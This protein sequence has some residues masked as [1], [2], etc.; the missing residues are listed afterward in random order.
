MSATVTSMKIP[1]ISSVAESLVLPFY[2]S[3]LPTFIMEGNTVFQ[4][5]NNENK[6]VIFLP[7]KWID[8]LNSTFSCLGDQW[9]PDEEVLPLVDIES[10]FLIR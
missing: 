3:F 7:S 5:E 10:V 1:E 2:C 4:F 6:D 8:F 9:T